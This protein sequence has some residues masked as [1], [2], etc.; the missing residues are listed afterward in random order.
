M[1]LAPIG[2]RV[3]QKINVVLLK[4]IFAVMLLALAVSMLRQAFA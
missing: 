3:A 4:R 1:S 2:A